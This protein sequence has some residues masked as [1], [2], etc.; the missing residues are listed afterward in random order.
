MEGI[1]E[2]IDA[3]Q[4]PGPNLDAAEML[5]AFAIENF[6]KGLMVAKGRVKFSGQK[7]PGGL[8]THDLCDLHELVKPTATI[9]P[10]LLES[11][12]YMSQWRARYPIPISVEDFWPMRAGGTM[13]TPG[14]SWPELLFRDL[15]LL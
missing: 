12:T 3:T 7:L 4:F 10:H 15:G 8:K 14:L 13:K 6:L 9:S 2:N 1:Q 11:L 5:I